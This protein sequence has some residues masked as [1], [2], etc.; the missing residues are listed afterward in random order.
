MKGR[1]IGF[2]IRMSDKDLEG[3]F[4]LWRKWNDYDHS[5]G[6]TVPFEPQPVAMKIIYNACNCPAS[7]FIGSYPPSDMTIQIKNIPSADQVL[8]Y[9]NN[10]IEFVYEQDC[11]TYE[12][13][14]TNADPAGV[15][16]SQ[17]T[18]LEAPGGS[19]GPHNKPYSQKFTLATTDD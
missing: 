5:L 14:F 16:I 17:F 1:P 10:Y 13:E 7:T 9:Q 11:G 2:D 6:Q 12:V 19:A 18:V 15:D 8:Q 3:G 4:A